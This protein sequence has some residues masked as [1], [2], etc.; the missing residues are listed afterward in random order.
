[1]KPVELV[2]EQAQRAVEA[3]QDMFAADRA[4]RGLGVT[5]TAL[6]PGESEA[7]MTVTAWML[8]GHGTCHGG[9]VFLL[10]DTAF[11]LA[12]NSFGSV[13]VAASADITFI[14]PVRE[15]ERLHAQARVRTRFSRR[16][17]FDVTVRRDDG[18]VVAEFRGHSHSTGK[19]LGSP[20]PGDKPASS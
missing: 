13:T 18:T 16:G 9:Y 5:A 10:A 8:N 3:A 17:I 1:M 20:P 15:G 4:S 6:A 2:G 7:E 14:A 11:S 12:C 19:P